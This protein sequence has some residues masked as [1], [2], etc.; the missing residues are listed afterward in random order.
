MKITAIED[1]I[2]GK[3]A[4]LEVRV[5]QLWENDHE[6]IRQVGLLE[7][8]TGIVKFVSWEKSNH[9]LLEEGATYR[10]RRLPVTKYEDFLSVALVSTTEIERIGQ[11]EIPTV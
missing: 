4:N 10:I 3:W 2:E 5:S 8:D 11:A 9:P 7:D 6:A 1:L